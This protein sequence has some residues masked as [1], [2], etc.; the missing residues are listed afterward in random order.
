MNE[1]RMLNFLTWN[2]RELNDQ[3]KKNNVKKHIK[4]SKPHVIALQENKLSNVTSTTT[5]E[6]VGGSY[7]MFL[8]IEAQ[9]A[10]GDMIL[11]WK[12]SM[13]TKLAHNQGTYT[14]S[15]DLANNSDDT[16]FRITTVYGPTQH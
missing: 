15:V 12:S 8:V 13:F 4:L 5:R 11:T 1:G 6:V 14:L 10:S 16:I 2:V 3:N 7:D 9:R